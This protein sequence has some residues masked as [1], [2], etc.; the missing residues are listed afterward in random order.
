MGYSYTTEQLLKL[1]Q[2]QP[3]ISNGKLPLPVIHKLRQFGICNVPQ[4][5][6]GTKGG[7]N[8]VRP[9]RAHLSKPLPHHAE[10]LPPQNGVCQNNLVYADENY[11]IDTITGYRPEARQIGKA[12]ENHNNLTKVAMTNSDKLS[13]EANNKQASKP[14][15]F[16][17]WNANS[18][19]NKSEIINNHITDYD[20]DV[21]AFTETKLKGDDSDVKPIGEMCPRGY[22]FLHVPRPQKEDSGVGGGVGIMFKANLDIKMVKKS[23]VFKSFEYMEVLLN[24]NPH[25]FRIIILYRPPPSEKNGLEHS[26]FFEEFPEFLDHKSIQSGNLLMVGDF[27]IHMDKPDSGYPAQFAGLLSAGNFKQHVTEKTHDKKHILDLVITKSE[28]VQI[29]NLQVL[30]LGDS[31]HHWIHF[32]LPI[33]KPAPQKK[34]ILY[35]N[36]KKI[37]KNEL[38][39]DIEKSDLFSNPANNVSDAVNQ[40]ND[41]LKKIFDKHA[42][43]KSKVVTI[44]PQTLW[45]NEAI[46]Q[47]KRERK[48]AERKWRKTRLTVDRQIYVSKRNAVNRLCNNAKKDFYGRK[49][50]ECQNDQKQIFKIANSLLHKSNETPLPEHESS[51]ELANR[52]ADFFTEK[53]NKI[54]QQLESAQSRSK[55]SSDKNSQK[56]SEILSSFEPASEEEIRKLVMQAATKSCNLD[57][58]PTWLLKECLDSLLPIITRV[59]NLSLTSAEVPSDMKEALVIPLIKKLT[60][61]PEILKNFRPVSNLSFLSKLIERVV[62]ARFENHLRK[63]NLHVK[64]Q[65][66]YKKFHS[67]ETA[68]L[69]VSNDILCDIDK[70]KCVLLVLLDLSAAFDTIDHETLLNRLSDKFGVKAQA[71]SWFR[72]YLSERTQSVLIGNSKSEKHNLKFGV[73]QGSILGPKQFIGYTAPLADVVEEYNMIDVKDRENLNDLAKKKNLKLHLYADDT[74]IY[75]AFEP[76]ENSKNNSVEDMEKCISEIRKWMADNFLKLNDDKTEFLILGTNKRFQKFT[77]PEIHIGDTAIKPAN[78]ARNIGAI[79]DSTMSMEKHVHTICQSAWYQLKRIGS[80]R[81]YLDLSSTKTLVHAFVTSK[82][83]Y[84]NSLLYGLPDKLIYKLERVQN[85]AARLVTRTTKYDSITSVLEELHWLPIKERINFKILLLTYKALNGE[86][87]EYISELLEYRTGL[88]SR[89]KL[90]LKCPKTKMHTYGDRSFSKAAP[91]LWNSIPVELRKSKSTNS[92]KK[93]LKTHLFKKA[94][95]ERRLKH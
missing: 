24:S 38:C 88:R 53:I 22:K 1:R 40:Y 28:S 86:G 59:V 42:P 80:I 93:N 92:F 87:P 23:S 78:Q 73:P 27:N 63:N 5:H 95:E 56:C 76:N 62:D 37:D 84:L 20:L 82:F 68:L 44:R 30:D 65:S 67:T 81:K 66:A 6:R 94:M 57:P 26:T 14:V 69:R 58:F 55:S 33:Q 9:I 43:L 11:S 29:E 64:W 2:S 61:D 21:I 17:L 83:D 18:V 48:R 74:Q 70:G 36:L 32:Q 54:R 90:E 71:L 39:K 13:L 85:A 10:Y 75:L 52:F 79:F 34:E 51:Q 19:R 7:V 31:D 16:A 77:K 89:E 47:A 91:L 50:S 8:K 3:V 49:I 25:C 46:G 12:Q 35:R 15:N 4:T 45:Y 41:T 72:S 60:L